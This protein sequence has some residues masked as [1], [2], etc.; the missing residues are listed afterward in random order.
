MNKKIKEVLTYGTILT[1]VVSESKKHG[2]HVRTTSYL[3]GD[4]IY[5][6]TKVNGEVVDF[7]DTSKRCG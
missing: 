2:Y 6:V 5:F 3:Y 1:D 4:V 7:T